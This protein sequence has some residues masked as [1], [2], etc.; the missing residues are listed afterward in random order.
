[1]TAF[2]FGDYTVGTDLYGYIFPIVLVDEDEEKKKPVD[3][4][5]V[6]GKVLSSIIEDC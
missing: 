3:S 2:N 6:G 4:G 1:M 5:Q